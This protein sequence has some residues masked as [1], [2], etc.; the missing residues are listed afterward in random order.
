M[1][2]IP[3][4]IILSLLTVNLVPFPFILVVIK[5]I[6]LFRNSTYKF[7]DIISLIVCSFCP[8]ELVN[9]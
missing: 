2:I 8:S 4:K 5:I 1:L 3:D 9:F 7:K 6:N